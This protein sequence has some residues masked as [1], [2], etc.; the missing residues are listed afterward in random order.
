VVLSVYGAE[1]DDGGRPLKF[2]RTFKK[3]ETDELRLYGLGGDDHFTV[4]ADVPRGIR[5][6]II[7]GRGQDTF[8]VKGSAK[9]LVYDTKGGGNVLVNDLH[10]RNMISHRRDVN[11]YTFRE[12][13]YGS[14]AWPTAV[15]GYNIDDGAMAGLG[16]TM[17]K[18]GFRAQPY[19]SQQRLTTLF[20]FEY[21]AYQIRYSGIFNDLYRHYDLV[22]NAA[23]L[24]PALQ[25]FFGLGNETVRDTALPLSYYRVRYSYVAGDILV[26]KR[27][28][29][30]KFSVGVGPAFYYYWNNNDRN[31]GRILDD[32]TEYGLDSMSI[33]S[34]QVYGGGKLT[35]DFNSVDNSLLPTRGLRFHADG[36]AQTG[37]NESTLPLF[38]VQSDLTMYAP[39]SN[40]ERFIL[41]LRAGGGHIF[42]DELQYWQAL[43]LGANNYLRGYRKNRFSGSSMAYG[44]AELRWRL[45]NLRGRVLPGEVGVVG[46][47]DAGRVWLKGE[48]SDKWH[49]AYG[50]GLYF[51]PYNSVLISVLGAIS[52]EERLINISL[53]A[54]LNIT[55]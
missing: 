54:G 45:A 20:A 33:F 30:N 34:P 29:H 52:E 1:A 4:D 15:L 48:Q 40:N 55:F 19:T 37:L 17:T 51:T 50:G 3:T 13:N 8:D 44:S 21:Q 12:N 38:R 31:S 39:L 53:G 43:T 24:N 25:N 22:V 5:I 49:L 16:A 18:R 14:F 27:A 10:T 11:D 35:V 47:Q 42:S 36:I 9:T 23:L 28:I 41:T 46:F 6:R 7:G 26:R 32:A 2:R